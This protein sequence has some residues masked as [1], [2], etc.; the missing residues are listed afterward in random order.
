MSQQV[1]TGLRLETDNKS[2]IRASNKIS[3]SKKLS[4]KD[5]QTHLTLLDLIF[6][7]ISGQMVINIEDINDNAPEFIVSNSVF[8]EFKSE[9]VSL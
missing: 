9:I 7:I 8:G 5:L 6:Y 3:K 1:S 2:K 4:N